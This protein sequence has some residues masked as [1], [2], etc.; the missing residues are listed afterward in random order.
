MIRKLL[1]ALLVVMILIQFIRPAKN[2][3]NDDTYALSTKYHVPDSVQRILQVACNDCHSNRTQYPWY[4]EIQPVA[5]WLNHHV[6]DGKR[7][8]NYSEFASS[9]LA[10]QNH[11]FEETIEEVKEHGMPLP[12]Y[13]W[14]GL[15]GKADLTDDQRKMLIDWAQA[16]M[17]TLKAH[18]PP[19][20][21]IMKRRQ[22][23]TGL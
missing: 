19:D 14:F 18:Y 20:S 16:Q 3:S 6:T 9:N 7:H 22:P 5:W 2:L 13:T 8:L 23:P 15:H 11:K 17:D 21:L 1:I 12:S 4:A 10:R